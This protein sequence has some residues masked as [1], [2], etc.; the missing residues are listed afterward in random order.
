MNDVE[1]LRYYILGGTPNGG[2]FNS[3]K[4]LTRLLKEY[5]SDFDITESI[6]PEGIAILEKT[7]SSQPRT[8][9]DLYKKNGNNAFINTLS[10]S[11]IM[12]ATSSSRKPIRFNSSL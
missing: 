12:D 2:H 6:S 7:N 4:Q 8:K 5:K 3:L 9:G 1:N 11:C 10:K